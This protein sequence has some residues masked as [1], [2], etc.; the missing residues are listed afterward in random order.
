MPDFIDVQLVGLDKIEAKLIQLPEAAG[1][2]GVEYAD[3]Y[4]LNVL[5]NKEIPAYKH[6]SYMAAYGKAPASGFWYGLAHGLIDV[7]YQRGKEGVT[8]DWHI[9]GAGRNAH[10]TNDNPA[11]KW[12][13]SEEQARLNAMIGWLRVSQIIDKYTRNIVQSFERGVKRAIEKLGLG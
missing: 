6:I 7:P 10:I 5:V 3:N 12:V 9:V 11:A 13:Y 1:D 8:N 4:L 2:N